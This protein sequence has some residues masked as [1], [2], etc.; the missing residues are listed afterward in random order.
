MKNV[1]KVFATSIGDRECWSLPL[2]LS[3]PPPLPP[4]PPLLLFP[5]CHQCITTVL[6]FPLSLTISV[7]AQIPNW[8]IVS[9]L[10]SAISKV[11]RSPLQ[12]S[13]MITK[14]GHAQSAHN[15]LWIRVFFMFFDVFLFLFQC[16]EH[17]MNTVIPREGPVVK[18][19]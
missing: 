14:Y 5:I 9:D 7:P 16:R 3:F 18:V 19:M 17:L 4:P 2:S 10:T 11:K 8:S 15:L 6:E 13:Q 12:V 1:I